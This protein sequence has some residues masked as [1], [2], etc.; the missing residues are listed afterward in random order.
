MI[1]ID[2]SQVQIPEEWQQKVQQAM[3][4]V[5]SEQDPQ[6]R[7]EIINDHAEIWKE[8]KDQLRQL[9]YGKCW[10]CESKRRRCD[11][12]VDHFRPK[13]RVLD[14][15]DHGGYWWLA[16]E[17]SNFRYS[18]TYC[19]SRRKDRVNHRSGG[20][21][22]HFPLLNPNDRATYQEKPI[23]NERPCLLDPANR[24]DPEMLWFQEDGQPVPKHPENQ[25]SKK[26]ALISIRLY[27]LDYYETVEDRIN[28]YN[29]IKEFVQ[30]GDILFEINDEGALAG[31]DMVQKELKKR[32]LPR[33]EFSA[34]AR[35]YIMGFR[36]ITRPWLDQI[37]T[38]E[39]VRAI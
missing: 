39:S 35:A 36:S 22:D 33:S 14:D 6:K 17:C 32:L 38:D 8:L 23:E 21:H 25:D 3:N 13:G 27:H 12:P 5:M 28:L 11:D 15:P 2:T 9:S 18:C 26:R 20:K 34:T 24:D 16:F 37:L 10:Y 30:Y 4:Q 19:N 1:Y 29:E 7:I 31:L